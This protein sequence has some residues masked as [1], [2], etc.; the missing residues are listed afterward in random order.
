MTDYETSYFNFIVNES[1]GE[2]LRI[3]VTMDALPFLTYA[4]SQL[5]GVL[6]AAKLSNGHLTKPLK[7]RAIELITECKNVI[8][9]IND[10]KIE[11]LATPEKESELADLL[12]LYVDIEYWVKLENAINEITVI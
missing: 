2:R 11:V 12:R 4:L 10:R 9:K 6:Q 1:D 5:S 3:S 8:Q 7:D